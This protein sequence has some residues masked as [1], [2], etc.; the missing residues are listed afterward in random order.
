MVCD[1]APPQPLPPNGSSVVDI[2]A[3]LRQTQGLYRDEITKYFAA[4]DCRQ[5]VRAENAK[6]H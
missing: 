2:A 6:L 3:A 5:R 4:D 1:P